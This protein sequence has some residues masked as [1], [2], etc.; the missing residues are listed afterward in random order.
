MSLSRFDAPDTATTGY[1]RCKRA[2]HDIYT[3]TY[4]GNQRP[5]ERPDEAG[6]IAVVDLLFGGRMAVYVI[7]G[8]AEFRR[9]RRLP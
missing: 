4:L 2:P 6:A 1:A 5:P 9:V 8:D 7:P 3:V